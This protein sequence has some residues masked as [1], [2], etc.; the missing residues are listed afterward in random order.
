MYSVQYVV[1]CTG[2]H[3]VLLKPVPPGENTQVQYRYTLSFIFIFYVLLQLIIIYLLQ[4]FIS[5]EWEV[6]RHAQAPGNR[7]GEFLVFN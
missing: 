4:R 3:P 7:P 6:L 1:V 5:G 2:V